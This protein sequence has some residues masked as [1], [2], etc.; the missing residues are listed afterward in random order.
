MKNVKLEE[1]RSNRETLARL[2]WDLTPQTANIS[3]CEVKSPK[4]L[5]RLRQRLKSLEGYYFY[6]DVWNCRARL[7]LMHNTGDGGGRS[8]VIE[9]FHNPL[10]EKA[11]YEAGG[12]INQSGWYP[13]SNALRSVLQR[14]LGP[15]CNP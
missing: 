4:E 10:L 8:E 13:M 1:V 6:V 3:D 2:R 11:V 5:E 15:S 12:S 9:D 14:K 7:A